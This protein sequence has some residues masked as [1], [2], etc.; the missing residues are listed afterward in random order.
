M[1]KILALL[2]RLG[3][4]PKASVTTTALDRAEAECRDC[5]DAR[6]GPPVKGPHRRTCQ[7]RCGSGTQRPACRTV[8]SRDEQRAKT[9]EG[10]GPRQSLEDA[11][12][13]LDKERRAAWSRALRKGDLLEAFRSWSRHP[14]HHPCGKRGE[15]HGFAS[16]HLGSNLERIIRAS[17][18]RCSS[19]RAPTSR[20]RGSG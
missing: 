19:R 4:T 17:R 11:K 8:H 14:R 3:I 6:A 1:D 9:G 16:A 10:K 2:R 15:S 12:A 7:D 18:C 5:R 13:I 20:S